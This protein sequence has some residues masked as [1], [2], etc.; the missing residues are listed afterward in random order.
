M[1]K[2]KVNQKENRKAFFRILKE[3]GLYPEWIKCRRKR[4]ANLI[5]MNSKESCELF[6][7]EKFGDILIYSFGW[8]CSKISRLWCSLASI[9]ERSN[10]IVKSEALMDKIKNIVKKHKIIREMD[11]DWGEREF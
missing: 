7:I 2:I 9:K 1:A 5:Q 8:D 3:M 4:I 10:D 6:S 11:D